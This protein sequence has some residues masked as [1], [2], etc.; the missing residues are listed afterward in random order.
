MLAGQEL[1]RQFTFTGATSNEHKRTIHNRAI[2]QVPATAEA[3]GWKMPQMRKNP[4]APKTLMRQLL[5][6]R[7]RMGQRFRKGQT[8][9][10]HHHQCCA[11]TI[12]SPNALRR[13]HCA[14]GEQQLENPWNDTGFNA[15]A[16]KDRPGVNIR[17]RFMQHNAAVAAV[18]KILLQTLTL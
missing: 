10:L 7:V 2:L 18:D 9:H 17:L 1:Q 6:T 14:A 16:T 12:P 15:R 8:A 3:Y 5:L 4:F 11:T 13:G